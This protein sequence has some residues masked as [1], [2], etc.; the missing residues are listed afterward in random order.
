MRNGNG[1]WGI[2]SGD[3]GG[4]FPP[5]EVV[6]GAQ[7]CWD[8]LVFV[9]FSSLALFFCVFL[10]Y[11]FISCSS[12][13]SVFSGLCWSWWAFMSNRFWLKL[14]EYRSSQLS[15]AIHRSPSIS[16]ISV[17]GFFAWCTPDLKQCVLSMGGWQPTC[18]VLQQQHLTLNF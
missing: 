3:G 8:M 11:I 18:W 13:S 14:C 12:P 6:P 15:V 9:M 10:W 7:V 1:G 5:P 16:A 17:T 2:S 4:F